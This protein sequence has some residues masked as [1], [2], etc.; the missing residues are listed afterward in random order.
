MARLVI[1]S[2]P[3]LAEEENSPD[4]AQSSLEASINFPSS[5]PGYREMDTRSEF[6]EATGRPEFIS[7]EMRSTPWFPTK[8]SEINCFG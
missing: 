5:K 1:S 3:E 8:L 6:N 2:Q 4:A 7:K